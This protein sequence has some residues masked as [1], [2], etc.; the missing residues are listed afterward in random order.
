MGNKEHDAAII[1]GGQNGL[2]C[3]AYLARAGLD[4][5]LLEA[6]HETGGGLDTLE[7]C[8]HKYNFHAVYHMMA[9]IMPVYNDFNLKDKGVRYI[10]PE[11]MAASLNI[12]QRPVVLYQDP[13]KTAQYLA[14]SFSSV[15][16]ESFTKMYNDFKEY[17][18]KIIMPLTYVPAMPALDLVMALNTAK[19]EVGRRY[20]EIS[21]LT[22]IEILDQYEFSEVIKAAL[23]NLFSMWGLSNYDGV[24]FLFPLYVYRMLN[25]ALIVGGSHRLSSALHKVAV[26]AGVEII[27]RAEVIKVITTNGKASGVLLKDGSEIKSKV[28]VSTVDPKQNF[29]EF[30]EKDQVPRDLIENAKNWE[31]EKATFFGLH[32]GLK[33]SPLYAG[34]EE[35]EDVNQALIVFN[36]IRDIDVILNHVDEIEGGSL[37]ETPL[38]HATCTTLFDPL[39][40]PRGCHTGRFETLVPYKCDWDALKDEYV[41]KCLDVWREYAPNLEPLHMLPYPPTYISEKFKD[42]VQGSFK[43]GS[44]VSLQMGYNRPNTSCSQVRTPIEGFYVCG[45]STNPGGM[46]IGGGGYIGANIIAE[47]L[48]VSTD[49]EEIE[50]VR[51]AREMGFIPE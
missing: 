6:R 7:Y 35:N 50:S 44:Y 2:I 15:D 29:L 13:E 24:G 16:G 10:Y 34:S 31:W 37:P 51:N 11:V 18:E 47:D 22:P 17:S 40:A 49:W 39:Q 46:I 12:G 9:E 5:I 43:Q 30:F 45:A 25:A 42:M 32:V 41:K 1:G 23:F 21:D 26:A 20:N 3:S 27:D 14:A 8:G 36:G 4:V 28:V 38:G 33:E 19:D 48:E